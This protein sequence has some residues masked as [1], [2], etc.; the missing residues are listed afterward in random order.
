MRDKRI[1][2]G[3]YQ[4][5]LGMQ[6]NVLGEIFEYS[7]ILRENYE[8]INKKDVA[9]IFSTFNLSIAT[10]EDNDSISTSHN[11]IQS[12]KMCGPHIRSSHGILASIINV[13]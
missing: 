6:N 8:T 11:Y 3:T 7:P 4:S 13:F 12:D 9:D 10:Y 2:C 5:I 1:V